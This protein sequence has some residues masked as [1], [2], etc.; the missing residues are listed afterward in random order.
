M[1]FSHSFGYD[2]KKRY[3]L[4]LIDS[5]TLIFSA[6]NLV[7]ILN[8]NTKEQKYLKTTSGGAVGAIRA[9]DFTKYFFLNMII[10]ISIYRFIHLANI[11]QLV[12]KETIPTLTSMNIHR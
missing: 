11:L 7:Q 3:N 9:S 2:C 5:D 8:V 10:M 4:N 1:N 6:G 12:K